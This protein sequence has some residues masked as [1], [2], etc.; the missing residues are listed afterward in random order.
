MLFQILM[1]LVQRTRISKHW[2]MKSVQALEDSKDQEVPSPR[3]LLKLM[4]LAVNRAGGKEG[5][6]SKSSKNEQTQRCTSRD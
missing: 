4:I 1:E 3:T 2:T 6:R 5:G